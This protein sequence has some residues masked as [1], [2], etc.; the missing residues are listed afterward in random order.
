[1][2]EGETSTSKVALNR[3]IEIARGLA[4]GQAELRAAYE[5]RPITGPLLKGRARLVDQAVRQIWKACGLPDSLALA[6]VGGYGRGEL[7]PA[8][9]VDL[10][11]LLPSAPDAAL[12]AKLSELVSSLWD[13]GLDIGHSVR[14]VEECLSESAQD[15]T[16]QTNLLEA[17]LLVGNE[18]LF[19]AFVVRF[20]DALDPNCKESPGGLR[21]LQLLGWISRAA[22]FG[23]HWRDLVRRKLITANEAT[24]LRQI[25]RFLQHVRIRLHHL[26]GRCEDRLLFDHQERIARAMGFEASPGKRASEVFMQRYYVEAKKLT[27]INAILLQNYGTELFPARLAPAVVINDRFQCVRE[28]LDRSEEHTSEL[29]V[30]TQS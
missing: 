26:T 5:A 24:D 20:R 16:V 22:R 1:M 11:I 28:L 9:D 6:A 27:Q 13:V 30:T 29:Q 14:T 2:A 3:S 19:E 21:D 15:V 17:R 4:K 7:F 25:E 23:L 12:E 18:A 8:S 10:L